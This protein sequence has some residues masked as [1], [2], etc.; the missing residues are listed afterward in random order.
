MSFEEYWLTVMIVFTRLIVFFTVLSFFRSTSIPMLA[1]TSFVLSISLF[2][3]YQIEP[4]TPTN[5]WEIVGIVIINVIIGFL[6]AYVIELMISII[7]IGGSLLDMDIGLANPFYD[8]IS[9]TQATIL[10][11]IFYYIFLLIF[12]VS[13]GFEKLMYGIIYTFKLSIQKD[14]LEKEEN[15]LFFIELFQV[16][17]LGALQIALPFMMGTFLLYI[18]LLLLSKVVDKMNILMNVFGIKIFVGIGMVTIMIP[19]LMVIFQQVDEQMIE[20][21]YE[22]IGF[23]FTK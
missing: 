8:G 22:Y 21:F 13:G 12:L 10:S 3:A 1:K 4:I 7:K 14:F 20:K 6:L 19:A 17:F 16:M 23:I 11:K 2:V 9:G 15:M 5:A 18:A